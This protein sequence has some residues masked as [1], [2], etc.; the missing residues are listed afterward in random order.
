LTS[1]I[2]QQNAVMLMNA[3]L[4]ITNP[5]FLMSDFT[6]WLSGRRSNDW[7]IIKTLLSLSGN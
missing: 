1:G 3:I 7:E 4:I 5:L 6:S 2:V